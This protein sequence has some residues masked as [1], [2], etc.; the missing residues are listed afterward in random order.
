MRLHTVTQT[1]IQTAGLPV[2][3]EE[4]ERGPGP[5]C[6]HLVVSLS[7]DVAHTQFQISFLSTMREMKR[8]WSDAEAMEG[9]CSQA[10]SLWLDQSRSEGWG[11]G[12]LA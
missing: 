7:V 8:G 6:G 9:P 11:L 1:L 12:D 2:D 3:W 5:S 10:C 4:M